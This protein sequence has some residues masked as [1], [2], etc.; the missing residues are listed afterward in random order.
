MIALQIGGRDACPM[1]RPANVADARGTARRP[2]SS[3]RVSSFACLMALL[4]SLLAAGQAFGQ[5]TLSTVSTGAP[6]VGIAVN[7]TQNIIYITHGDNTLTYIDGATNTVHQVADP[8]A[9]KH[10]LAA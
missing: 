2:G 3:S 10:D 6:T 9:A 1:P 8:G 5:S 4:L 7:P